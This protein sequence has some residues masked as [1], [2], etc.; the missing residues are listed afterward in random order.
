MITSKFSLRGHFDAVR[1][2]AFHPTESVL[3]SGSE[4][5]TIKLWNLDKSAVYNKK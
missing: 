1:C 5:Q 2:L 4:D 3:I